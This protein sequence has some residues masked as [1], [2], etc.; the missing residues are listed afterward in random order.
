ML[1]P[2]TLRFFLDRWDD[3]RARC[4]RVLEAGSAE[5]LGPAADGEALAAYLAGVRDALG[6]LDLAGLAI[7]PPFDARGRP[8]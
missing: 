2:D 8:N 7:A 6:Y 4:E 1:D 5:R 3:L